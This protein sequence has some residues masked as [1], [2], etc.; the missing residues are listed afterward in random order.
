[1]PA[2]LFRRRCRDCVL[3]EMIAPL[4]LRPVV[5]RERLA[6]P[7]QT[8]AKTKGL[9]DRDA[10]PPRE[11]VPA[12]LVDATRLEAYRERAVIVALDGLVRMEHEGRRIS[13]RPRVESEDHLHGLFLERPERTLRVPLQI[14]LRIPL[15]VLVSQ[16]ELA[17]VRETP[18]PRLL[19][20]IT[21]R[22]EERAIPV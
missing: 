11:E 15:E 14:E 18:E 2:G 3:R 16:P 21:R 19:A 4:R 12:H 8:D 6:H 20:P 1:M 13:D 5:R 9:L 7:G 10:L 17:H 22:N